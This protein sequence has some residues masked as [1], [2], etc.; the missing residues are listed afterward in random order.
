MNE[1]QIESILTYWFTNE[2]NPADLWNSRLWFFGGDKAR[3]HI[4]Q[5]FAH[6]FDHVAKSFQS[7]EGQC[8]SWAS[9]SKGKIAAIILLDQFPRIV[10]PHTRSMFKYESIIYS[11][12][13]RILE[14]ST[15]LFDSLPWPHRLFTLIS[16]THQED[17]LLVNQAATGL[18]SLAAQ[19]SQDPAHTSVLV[20]RVKRLF[21]NTESLLAAIRR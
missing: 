11:L 16:M 2:K 21:K 6:L 10:Y 17:E 8:P 1:I 9:S 4:L 19:L 14:D 13:K 5:N 15:A 12:T 3:A 18:L 7:C 20:T